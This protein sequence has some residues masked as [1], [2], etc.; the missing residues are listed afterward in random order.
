M[1]FPLMAESYAMLEKK[2]SILQTGRP[3][4]T[5]FVVPLRDLF[6]VKS[7]PTNVVVMAIV[8]WKLEMVT[9]TFL[10]GRQLEELLVRNP[11]TVEGA[12]AL[13]QWKRRSQADLPETFSAGVRSRFDKE[14]EGC[15]MIPAPSPDQAIGVS[16]NSLP[17]AR[18]TGDIIIGIGRCRCSIALCTLTHTHTNTDRPGVWSVLAGV[19]G[20]LPSR[21][22]GPP[23]EWATPL[24]LSPPSRSF[25]IQQHSYLDRWEKVHYL[26]EEADRGSDDDE[27]SRHRRWS[28]RAL[29]S[30]PCT[31][32]YSQHNIVDTNREYNHL[33]CDIYK[34]SDYDRLALSLISPLPN[35]QDFAI[36]V[37]MLLSNDGK[38]TLKL[39]KHP[40]LINFLLGHAGIFHHSRNPST[41][42]GKMCSNPKSSW[43]SQMKAN[44]KKTG[45]QTTEEAIKETLTLGLTSNTLLSLND[46]PMDID[47]DRLNVPEQSVCNVNDSDSDCE[48]VDDGLPKDPG[49]DRFKLKLEPVDCELFCARRTLGT[50]D[51]VGQRVLQIATILRNLSFIEENI[52]VLVKNTTFIRFLLLCNT[53]QWNILKNLG[54]DM[55]GNIASEFIVKDF[56]NDM[57][58][59]NL[60]KIIMRGLE[61]PDRAFCLSSLEV[62]NKLSQ[63]RAERGRSAA[64]AGGSSE[65][66]CTLIVN[67][68]GVIDTLVSLVTVEGKSYGPK[69]C[70]GMKLVETLPSGTQAQNQSQSQQSSSVTTTTTTTTAPAANSTV[71]SSTTT[72]ASS[73]MSII[74]STPIKTSAISTPTR[75]VAIA[76]QRLISITPTPISTSTSVSV[77]QSLTTSSASNSAMTP[78]Q[79]IQQQHAHQQAIHENEQFALAW[80]RATY[81]PCINGRIDHQE[82][83]KHYMTSCSKIGRRGIIS[84]LHFPRCVR[85]VFGGTVGPNP[86]K[87]TNPNDP[88]VLRRDK[89]Q[90]ARRKSVQTVVMSPNKS[91]A[92][93]V[94][95][96]NNAMDGTP[97]SSPA[98]PIL[99]AQ[100]SAPPKQREIVVTPISSKGDMKSQVDINTLFRLLYKMPR[101][102][103]IYFIVK[104]WGMWFGDLVSLSPI[105]I[106]NQRLSWMGD[107]F[108]FRLFFGERLGALCRLCVN[109]S[110]TQDWKESSRGRMLISEVMAHPHL[111]QALLGST[112]TTSTTT[113]TVSAGP[114]KEGQAGQGSST[115]LIKSLL[116]TK[117]NDCMSTVSMRTA[118][119][120]QNVAQ[121]AARQ[122]QQ[123][124]LA[125]QCSSTPVQDCQQP[126]TA[127][128]TETPKISRINGARQLF[129]ESDIGDPSVSSTT[130]FTGAIKGKKEPPQPPPP[131][132]APLSNNMKGKTQRIDNE[133]SD[134]I[135]NNSMASSSG[136]GTAGVGGI[137]STEE[138]DNSLTSFEGLLNGIPSMEN[139]L[140][141][142]SNSKESVK[143]VPS[144]ISMNKP[145][146]LA[147]LLEKKFEK[148]PPMLNG[149]LGKELRLGEKALDLVEN[150]IEKALNRDTDPNINNRYMETEIK[151]EEIKLEDIKLEEIKL[152][153]PDI[154]PILKRSASEEIVECEPKKPLLSSNI[155]GSS[156]AASPDPDSVSSSIGDEPPAT[157]STAAAKLFADIAADIL[158]DEDEEQ[159]L[160][161]AQGPP[162]IIEQ[163]STVQIAAQSPIQQIIMDNNQQMLLTQPRQIIVSQAQMQ[164]TNQM[165]ISTGTQLKTQGGQTVIV[166]NTSSHQRPVMIQQA[167]TGQFLLSQNLQGQMQ[168][169]ASSQ[170]GQYVL[171]TSGT[172]GTYMVAQPQTAVVHGQPQTVL[173]AQTS[174]P[175]GAGTKTIIILQ[176]QSN[177]SATHHQKV[178]VTPQGQQMVVTQVPRPVMHTS[179]VTNNVVS[180]PTKVIKSVAGVTATQTMPSANGVTEKKPDEPKK[181]KVVRDLTT[182]FVCEWGECSIETKFKS[183]NQVYLHVCAEHC[184]TGSEEIIC[185]WDRCDNMKRKRFSL[186]TH[187]HDKH[188]NTEAMRQGLVRRKQAAQGGAK[189][190]ATPQPTT[191]PHPGYAPDAALHAIKRHALEFVNPK[192]LQLKASKPSPPGV[193]VSS[194]RAGPS[195]PS[196]QDDNEG[197]VTK[198]IRLTASLI[199]RNLVIYSSHCKRYLKSYESHLANVALSNVESSRTIAQVLYDMNDGSTHR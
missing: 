5:S 6:A 107:R 129:T 84:P 98:S 14:R 58:A 68:H 69:A 163:P 117:V 137:S 59:V 88:P 110:S 41:I 82:L 100:L 118:T 171:Q 180:T 15:R 196:D 111:S 122:Q 167:N 53:S 3:G 40:R 164:Q 131:P 109:P 17:Q 168:I 77:S 99:K 114:S 153:E 113:V 21:V 156:T 94:M 80:L 124:L 74:T 121:V 16:P 138:G 169:V 172:Q 142:D 104:L 22:L 119:D 198:S 54:M 166:Q 188:C 66:S 125:Q 19:P 7:T 108:D 13:C 150:H 95:A 197:P 146:R 103:I 186:M 116:A 89:G 91:T 149:A 72:T 173:V 178:V 159:L 38:H 86:M 112:C 148:S 175:Q 35:E 28:A 92:L 71:A 4:K 70:I 199:L 50:Q 57:L 65:R 106:V 147:D 143:I 27:E 34:T 2:K 39:E 115:S 23:H 60:L 9:L 174:Q 64:Y 43:I 183:A 182:P 73:N 135:G 165:V 152:E 20:R 32:N 11:A 132:L 79:L 192:E 25:R 10:Q 87:P 18:D 81:E 61:S 62:L 42:S 161:E 136:L 48:T 29:H 187:L 52:P 83:Y 90:Q 134:S 93:T 51:Y 154:K 141:E 177:S 170:P 85:S 128:K 120:C 75:P 157:V 37:C 127:I 45:Q 78:Q 1:K 102:K 126:K 33:S 184:P 144:E 46:I 24:S 162:Q 101:K 133:D 195:S 31:Y 151:L 185:Q 44:L 47:S 56:Q 55:L 12:I 26:H 179:S 140:N 181:V 36:N 96:D 190:E 189:V 139:P 176:Q 30:V 76:P 8:E 145:L 63:K 67:N 97:I 130:Q 194:P 160:Q 191:N 105:S 158:E 123:R 49:C 193:S 155:N